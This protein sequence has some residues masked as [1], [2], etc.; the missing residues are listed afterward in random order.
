MQV[1]VTKSAVL[2]AVLHHA[3]TIGIIDLPERS[4]CVACNFCHFENIIIWEL[5]YRIYMKLR[6]DEHMSLVRRVYIKERYG[7]LGLIYY[8]CSRFMRCDITKQTHDHSPSYIS[9]TNPDLSY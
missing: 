1:E 2:T 7:L 4:Y 8:I 6:S 3:I 9:L 5:R